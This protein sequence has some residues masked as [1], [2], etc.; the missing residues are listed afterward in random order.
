ML[1]VQSTPLSPHA[2]EPRHSTLHEPAPQITGLCR[3]VPP[4]LHVTVHG[5]VAGHR[6]P[7]SHPSSAAPPEPQ[8]T[9]QPTAFVQLTGLFRHPSPGQETS[10]KCPA[11]QV[12][13][14][15]AVCVI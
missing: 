3:H 12:T 2:S 7:P 9:V 14:R 15:L 8:T 1:F 13:P 11:G 6:T 10:Q 5:P 4:P